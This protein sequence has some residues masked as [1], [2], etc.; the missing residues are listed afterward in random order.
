MTD[1]KECIDLG[2]KRCHQL[3][4]VGQRTEIQLIVIL[5]FFRIITGS[6]GHQLRGLFRPGGRACDDQIG[7]N[8]GIGKPS[9]HLRTILFPPLI[10]RAVEII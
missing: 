2:E 8:G 4:M 9:G 10:E 6:A 3:H 7:M 1:Q 5:N